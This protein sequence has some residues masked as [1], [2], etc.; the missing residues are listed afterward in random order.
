MLSPDTWYLTFDIW[1][2]HWYVILDIWSLVLD[3]WHRHLICYTWH[4]I[5]GTWYL[6]PVFDM[7]HLTP[8]TWHLIHNTWQLTCYHLTC[9]HMVLAHLTWYCDTWLDTIIP[10]T[11]IILHIHYYHFYGDLAWLLYCYQ[12][13][14]TPELLCS[15]TTLFL[16]PWNM[17]TPDIILLILYS[18][19]PRNWI[20]MDIGLLWTPYGH[21][22]W[23]IYNKILNLH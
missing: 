5:S 12:A 11:C 18:C 23:A 9:F 3:I 8:D 6:I 14:G 7:L 22:H 10:D 4:L 21:Y 15:W 20:I 1:H 19:W 16:N 2:Q 13:S 17:K